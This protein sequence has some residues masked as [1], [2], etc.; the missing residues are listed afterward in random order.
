M[1]SRD[2]L[3]EY[4][5]RG[6]KETSTYTKAVAPFLMELGFTDSNLDSIEE[7]YEVII[8]AQRVWID[9]CLKREGIPIAFLQIKRLGY[10]SSLDGDFGKTIQ[11]AKKAAI[12]M[13]IFTSGDVWEIYKVGKL[14]CKQNLL[15]NFDNGILEIKN[16]LKFL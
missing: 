2:K 7:D 5:L 9:R 10:S 13:V 12:P 6:L 4:A 1:I 14:V 15:N 11:A 8:D 3:L 16:W